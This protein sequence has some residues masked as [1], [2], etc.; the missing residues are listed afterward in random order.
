MTVTKKK[1]FGTDGVRGTA[2]I[3]PVTAETVLKLG[4]AITR[5]GKTR[6]PQHPTE[7]VSKFIEAMASEL[8]RV[9]AVERSFSETRKHLNDLHS[10]LVTEKEKQDADKATPAK[11]EKKQE[12][13]QEE[14]ENKLATVLH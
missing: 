12:N 6:L 1:I 7:A 5:L 13:G 9:D 11:D 3:E 2:N 8:K 10:V 4:R 14:R